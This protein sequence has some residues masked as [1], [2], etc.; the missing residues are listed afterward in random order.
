MTV[1][2]AEA[3][4]WTAIYSTEHFRHCLNSAVRDLPCELLSEALAILEGAGEDVPATPQWFAD[5]GVELPVLMSEMHKSAQ[6]P[7]VRRANNQVSPE[8]EALIRALLT[9]G[10]SKSAIART[11]RVNRRVV[12]RVARETVHVE[13]GSNRRAHTEAS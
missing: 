8:T 2:T 4:V 13:Q 10:Q 9:Q 7:Y 1:E 5:R 11:L 12:I 6:V 3:L